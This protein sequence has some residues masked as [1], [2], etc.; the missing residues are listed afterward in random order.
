MLLYKYKSL[1]NL[2]NVLDIVVN[3]RL[4]CAH[5]SELND[6]LE[7]RYSI[8]FSDG[9]RSPEE[10]V[11]SAIDKVKNQVRI[12]SLS[13]NFNNY[14]LWSHYASGHK[15]VA[16]EIEIPDSQEELVEVIYSP[17]D[18]VFFDRTDVT[19]DEEMLHLFNSKTEEWG[20]EE[21]YRI[22]QK[23][24]YFSLPLPVRK[25]Y[26]GPLTT[27][28][29]KSILKKILPSVQLVETELDRLQAS[30]KVNA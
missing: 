9:D 25:I 7:G 1:D 30:V 10:K 20:Y 22:L 3:Q 26:L 11:R 27:S 19:E 28:K 16:I 13:K 29:E 14:L 21:E 17:F 4:Y 8:F 5:W 6:P 18:S 12:A 2:W 24:K 15:G 23:G